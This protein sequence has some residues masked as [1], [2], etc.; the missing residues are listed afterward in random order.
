MLF[1]CFVLTLIRSAMQFHCRY[2]VPFYLAVRILNLGNYPFFTF[3]F[4]AFILLCFDSLDR[5]VVWSSSDHMPW[6]GLHLHVMN[7]S[8]WTPV[9][10]AAS[11]HISSF[12][13]TE[14]GLTSSNDTGSSSRRHVVTGGAGLWANSTATIC[15]LETP[16]PCG[17]NQLATVCLSGWLSSA[18]AAHSINHWMAGSRRVGGEGGRDGRQCKMLSGTVE[19]ENVVIAS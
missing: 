2:F 10:S 3:V 14:T 18:T 19:N 16:G 15:A 6:F 5:F 7:I 11:I 12:N 8:G 9:S 4:L 17:W 13:F 1:T